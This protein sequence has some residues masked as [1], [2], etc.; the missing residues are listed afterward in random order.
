MKLMMNQEMKVGMMILE[1][2]RLIRAWMKMNLMMMIRRTRQVLMTIIQMIL[3]KLELTI[4]MNCHRMPY[5]A[6]WAAL[7]DPK[8]KGELQMLVA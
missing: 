3:L 4:P 6:L 5:K 2:P 7:V 8:M 1:I